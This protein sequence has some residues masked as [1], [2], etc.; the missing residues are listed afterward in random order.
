MTDISPEMICGWL[1]EYVSVV[2]S[3]YRV[4]YLQGPEGVG[5]V[6]EE[7]ELESKMSEFESLMGL[8]TFEQK[9]KFRQDVRTRVATYADQLADLD[10][11]HRVFPEVYHAVEESR[12]KQVRDRFYAGGAVR[13]EFLEAILA[14]DSSSEEECPAEVRED[15]SHILGNMQGFGYCPECAKEALIHA[16]DRKLV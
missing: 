6:A 2:T 12:F 9:G 15:L 11:Y 14:Y 3:N 1:K 16:V 10:G 8:R 7:A 5:S 4:K 13:Q